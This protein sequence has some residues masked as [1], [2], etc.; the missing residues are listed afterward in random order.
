MPSKKRQSFFGL[1]L[2]AQGD[3]SVSTSAVRQLNQE[4]ALAWALSIP[5]EQIEPDPEQPRKI[6][7]REE[8]QALAASIG[9]HGVLQPILVRDTS[10]LLDDGRPRYRII[11]GERRYKAALLAGLTRLPA[12]VNQSDQAQTRVLQLLENMLRA[13]LDPIDEA[14]AIREL[15]DLE[16]L[17]AQQVALRLH[18]SHTYVTDRLLLL[19]YESVAEAVSTRK[20][21]PTPAVQVAR[22]NSAV[23]REV[24][25]QA[26]RK[27]VSVRDVEQIRRR[28]EQPEPGRS[29]D[30]STQR[31][32]ASS[33][34]ANESAAVALRA[35]P[36]LTLAAGVGTPLAVL[37]AQAN[38]KGAVLA[39]A[40]YANEQ[41]WSVEQFELAVKQL[42]D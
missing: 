31:E 24:L 27:S 33:V 42:P 28:Y 10:T 25:R 20:L 38:G 11:A 17:E 2:P 18:K 22:S 1:D 3:P 34:G 8:L 16:H 9:E 41:R 30:T 13:D 37:V 21:K 40:S 26:E 6:E 32:I 23:R 14:R 39:L 5:I 29:S 15:M 36:D 12:V 19:K 7:D 35:E 4:R